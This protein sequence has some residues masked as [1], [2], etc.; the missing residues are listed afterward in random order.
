MCSSHLPFFKCSIAARKMWRCQLQTKVSCGSL[1]TRSATWYLCALAT[2]AR[3]LQGRWK[4]LHRVKQYVRTLGFKNF[5]NRLIRRV[6]KGGL[7]FAGEFGRWVHFVGVLGRKLRLLRR[8]SYQRCGAQWVDS[9]RNH[10]WPYWATGLSTTSQK[11]D[12]QENNRSNCHWE[13]KSCMPILFLL[14]EY[15]WFFKTFLNKRKVLRLP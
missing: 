15:Y 10:T 1:W 9:G 11:G 8:T 12:W 7:Y 2:G 3:G 14:L 6:A 4:S 5:A 13:L